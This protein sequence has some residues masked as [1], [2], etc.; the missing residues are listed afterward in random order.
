MGKVANQPPRFRRPDS[1]LLAGQGW[2]TRE[3]R[4]QRPE[5]PL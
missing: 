3:W 1:G 5:R 2:V 4:I